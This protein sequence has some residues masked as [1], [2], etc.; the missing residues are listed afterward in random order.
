MG[1]DMYLEARK[2]V[3]GYSFEDNT[4]TYDALMDIVGLDKVNYPESPSATI[5]V[6]VGYWRKVNS[7]HQWFVDN[8]ADGVDECQSI[9]VSRE[10]LLELR[11]IVEEVLADHS[12]AKELLP[13]SS[14]FFFGSTDYDDWYF[15]DLENTVQILN[16]VLSEEALSSAD[17]YYRA[18]W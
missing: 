15:S 2:Y 13:T 10:K 11:G 8:L 16:R 12:K 1:L 9:Y 18:S 5:S 4:D 14:G 17:F 6:N 7:I 3:S